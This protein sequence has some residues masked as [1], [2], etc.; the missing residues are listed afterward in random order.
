MSDTGTDNGTAT[1]AQPASRST[2]FAGTEPGDVPHYEPTGDT[3][4]ETRGSRPLSAAQT[5][6]RRAAAANNNSLRAKTITDLAEFFELNAGKPIQSIG[7]SRLRAERNAI[8]GA[9]DEVAP[10]DLSLEWLRSRHG[11]GVFLLTPRDG[12]KKYC[13]TQ[14]VLQIAGPAVDPFREVAPEPSRAAVEGLPPGGASGEFLRWQIAQQDKQIAKLERENADLRAQ[15]Q[16]LQDKLTDGPRK[17]MGA[18]DPDKLVAMALG[19]EDVRDRKAGRK[20]RE[21]DRRRRAQREESAVSA[22]LALLRNEN[23]RLRKTAE[24]VRTAPPPAAAPASAA[25]DHPMLPA[26]PMRPAEP[27]RAPSADP[28]LELVQRLPFPLALATYNWLGTL[29]DDELIR[30]TNLLGIDGDDYDALCAALE[31]DF[32]D[33]DDDE[34]DETDPDDPDDELGNDDDL[35]DPDGSVDEG[36]DDDA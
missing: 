16:K 32:P 26:Q 14:C 8:A 10:G 34:E 36:D 17:G 18:L 22:Q 3:G 6:Q 20:Q 24:A 25:P 28:S 5:K 35:L 11:G 19:L 1:A 33:A 2:L 12:L 27:L 23:A 9:L 7:V 30:E 31:E 13:G 21:E 29:D 4:T 15:N